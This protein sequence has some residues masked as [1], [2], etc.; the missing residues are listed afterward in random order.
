[1]NISFNHVYAR[2]HAW[3]CYIIRKMILHTWDRPRE[4]T[5]SFLYKLTLI[6]HMEKH[7]ETSGLYF[8]AAIIPV[9]DKTIFK[10]RGDTNGFGLWMLHESF[11]DE[12]Y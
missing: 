3:F 9:G 7:S 12:Y 8:F 2:L 1:M 11:W 5:I 10:I 4:P 6:Y